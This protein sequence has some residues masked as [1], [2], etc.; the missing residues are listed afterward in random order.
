M[1]QLMF[2]FVFVFAFSLFGADK[3]KTISLNISGMTCESCAGSV[4]KALQKVDGVKKATVD[5]KNKKATVV[6]ASSKATADLL[7]K[8]VSDAGFDASEGTMTGKTEMK[9]HSK[10]GSEDCGDG[11]CGDEDAT[12]AKKMKSKKTA[13]KKS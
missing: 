10:S 13:T 2:V 4:Q 12:H 6:L 1:K 3:S 5:L 11:C 7:I 8:A 9:K